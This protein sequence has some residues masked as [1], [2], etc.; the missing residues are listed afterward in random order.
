M[1]GAVVK[2][3]IKLGKEERTRAENGFQKMGGDE[4]LTNH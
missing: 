3:K 2:T 1:V 4:F